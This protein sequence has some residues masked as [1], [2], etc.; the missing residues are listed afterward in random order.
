MHLD[1]LRWALQKLG[2]DYKEESFP[3]GGS[4]IDGYEYRL[5]AVF[6]DGASIVVDQHDLAPSCS[7]S[8]HVDT[9]GLQTLLAHVAQDARVRVE[10]DAIAF[11]MYSRPV[12]DLVRERFGWPSLAISQDE[13]LSI[14]RD[15]L[16]VRWTYTLDRDFASMYDR[17]ESS[18]GT[19]TLDANGRLSA[20]TWE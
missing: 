4:V 8:I 5:T 16:T 14:S 13:A 2:I 18:S 17:S 11:Q 10:G 3:Y 15:G 19:A 7:V 20:V 6:P 12:L 1:Q 9:P